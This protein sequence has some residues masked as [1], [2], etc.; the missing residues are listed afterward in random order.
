LGWIAVA[1]RDIRSGRWCRVADD[2]DAEAAS[3]AGGASRVAVRLRAVVVDSGG[4][5]D[6]DDAISA[7]CGGRRRPYLR[8]GAGKVEAVSVVGRGGRRSTHRGV[9]E[10]VHPVP[11]VCGG[12]RRPNLRQRT[13]DEDAAVCVAGG[14]QALEDKSVRAEAD[15]AIVEAAYHAVFDCHPV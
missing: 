9:T 8:K 1:V 5:A 11:A 6:K 4:V 2:E 10:A 12:L 3:A 7:V 13:D 14:G 15:E